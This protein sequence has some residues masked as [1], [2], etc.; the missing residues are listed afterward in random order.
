VLKQSGQP[1]ADFV[2]AYDPWPQILINVEVADRAT[3][4]QSPQVI[5][6]L[7][8]AEAQLGS[9]GRLNVRASGTQPM[10]RV[11]VE[12][13]SYELRDQVAGSI[14]AALEANAGAKVYSR[15]DLTHALGD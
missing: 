4:N 6:S 12:A 9:N 11:M 13:D 1:S 7:S 14:L 3:W 10:I 15:V 8:L 2:E 5:E